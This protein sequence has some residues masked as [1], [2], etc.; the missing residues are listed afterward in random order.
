MKR[1]EYEPKAKAFRAW[2]MAEGEKPLHE[3]QWP[4][5]PADWLSVP[6][7]ATC[8]TPNCVAYGIQNPVRFHENADGMYRAVCGECSEPAT[9]TLDLEED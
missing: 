5:D 9:C 3:R 7:H 2:L 6:G 1:S 8:A 4:E